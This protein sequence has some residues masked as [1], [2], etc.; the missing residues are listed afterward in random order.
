MRARAQQTGMKQLVRD[1]E[2][3][4]QRVVKIDPFDI[5]A[6]RAL[7]IVENSAKYVLFMRVNKIIAFIYFKF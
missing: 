5:H 1:I 7:G 3:I 6:H 4:F 2:S